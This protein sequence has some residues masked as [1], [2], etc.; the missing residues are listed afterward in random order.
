MNTDVD[1]DYLVNESLTFLNRENMRAILGATEILITEGGSQAL[2]EYAKI[3]EGIARAVQ[4]LEEQ[5]K[6]EDPDPMFVCGVIAGLTV[7]FRESEDFPSYL[8]KV[9]N[10]MK[11]GL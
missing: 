11:L 3:M 1:I 2:E 6:H 7:I 4:T 5:I 10:A 8:D 9:N